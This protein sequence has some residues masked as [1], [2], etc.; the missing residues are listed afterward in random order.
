MLGHGP[1]GVF[2]LGQLPG[3]NAVALGAILPLTLTL[4]A[5]AATGERQ[6]QPI[7]AG[8][9]TA[10]VYRERHYDAVARGARLILDIRLLPGRA[11][12][13]IAAPAEPLPD[14]THGTAAG[15]LLVLEIGIVARAGSASGFDAIAHDNE[16]LLLA[17]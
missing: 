5:G 6:Q 14:A 16:F 7:G 15:A 10:A 13:V 11:I 2:A 3:T 8:G 12:G 1:L 9:G 4:E 17:A